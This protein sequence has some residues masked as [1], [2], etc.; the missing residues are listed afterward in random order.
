MPKHSMKVC[1]LHLIWSTKERYPYFVD[2]DISKKVIVILRDI[3]AQHKIYYKTGY[4]NPEH[5][6][7]LVDLPVNLSIEKFLQ[8]LKGISSHT[9]NEIGLFKTRFSWS[10]RYAAFSVSN[11]K[12]NSII[13]YINTQKEHHKK[14]TFLDEW[15]HY[16][17]KYD[18]VGSP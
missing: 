11:S 12:I 4:I 10:K 13:Q 18:L 15:E 16:M 8:Y 5:V 17:K 9:I 6:H 2:A 7:L 1:W 3:C 14:M